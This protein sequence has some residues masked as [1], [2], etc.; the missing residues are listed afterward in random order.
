LDYT[1][2]MKAHRRFQFPFW[3]SVYRDAQG[4]EQVFESQASTL[5][6]HLALLELQEGFPPGST[7]EHQL[8][9]GTPDPS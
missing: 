3:Q 9:W 7:A 4:H 5:T 6:A 2:P 8:V 1:G